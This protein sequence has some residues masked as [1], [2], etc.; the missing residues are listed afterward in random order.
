MLD[1]VMREFFTRWWILRDTIFRTHFFNHSRY[2]VKFL[3]F[4]FLNLYQFVFNKLKRHIWKVKPEIW[5]LWWDL[6]SMTHIRGGTR[7]SRPETVEGEAWDLRPRTYL[8][9]PQRWDP[10]CSTLMYVG[11]ETLKL[12]LQTRDPKPG[13]LIKDGNW[14]PGL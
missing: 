12:E 2:Y 5:V 7:N 9:G 1:A 14:D 11:P 10:R 4:W 6:G 3:S 13:V 8:R